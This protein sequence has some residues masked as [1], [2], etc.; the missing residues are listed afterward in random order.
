MYGLTRVLYYRALDYFQTIS[1]TLLKT[2]FSNFQF[3]TAAC[4]KG[5]EMNNLYSQSI[6]EQ[7]T[8]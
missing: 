8:K 6:K 3:P 7:R 2:K 4:Q 1:V 5:K